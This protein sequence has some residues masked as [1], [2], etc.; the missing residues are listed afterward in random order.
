MSAASTR[1]RRTLLARTVLRWLAA[2]TALLPKAFRRR[3]GDD[4]LLAFEDWLDAEERGA[5][6]LFSWAVRA[7]WVLVRTAVAERLDPTAWT[8]GQQSPVEAMARGELPSPR[9]RYDYG[10]NRMKGSIMDRLM[11]DLR[12]AT[13]AL[14]RRPAYVL[15]AVLT[16]ALGVGANAAI[17]SLVD[18][19]ILRPLPYPDP[20]ELVVVERIEADRPNERN[21]MSLLDTADVADLSK[22]LDHLVGYFDTSV[23]LAAEGAP[24]VLQ[25]AAVAGSLL[26]VFELAPQM[27]R[28]LTREDSGPNAPLRAL[29]GHGLWQSRFGGRGD[30]VGQVAVFDD[31][32]YEIVGV[33][34]EG[35]S[36]PA[37]T[38]LWINSDSDPDGCGRGCHLFDAIGRLAPGALLGDA[39]AELARI[40]GGLAELHP[41]SN[42]NKTFVAAPLA[43]HL[44]GEARGGLLILLG[45]VA[46]V[47]LIAAANLAGLQL[48]HGASRRGEMGVRA[49]L[50]ASRWR[51]VRLV[52]AETTLLGLVGGLAGLGLAAAALRFVVAV[53]PA[54]VPRLGDAAVDARVFAF[55]LA[56][57]LLAALLFGLYPAWRLAASSAGANRARGPVSDSADVRLRG[58]LLVGEIALSM[59]LLVG[60]GLLLKTY[61]GLLTLDLG[62]DR[63]DVLCFFVAAPESRYDEPEKVVALTEQIHQELGSLP[64]IESV[65]GILGRPFSGNTLGTSF[66]LLDEPRPAEGDEPSTRIRIVMPGYFETLGIPL[67]V[68]RLPELTDRHGGQPVALVNQAWVRRH[69]ADRSPI[70]RQLE[71]G[72]SFGWDEPPRTIVGVVGDVLGESITGAPEV[73]V[74]APQAQM[75][76][77]WM[78]M[79]VRTRGGGAEPWTAIEAAVRRVDPLLPLHSRETLA[80]S[81]DRAQGPSRF[82]F[83][84]LAC[85]AALAVVLAA[86]GL[87]G[88]VSYVVARRSRELAVR[89]AL[90]A[91]RRG[92]VALVLAQGMR[93]VALGAAIGLLASVGA[94]RFLASLLHRVEAF[95]PATY[96]AVTGVLG[97]VAFAAL[98]APARRAGRVAPALVLKEE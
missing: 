38:V 56:L 55:G 96:A 97:L 23:T 60:A 68:G 35:F 65:G 62:F 89:L 5:A 82:Y 83:V 81:V 15:V 28:D 31:E 37:E 6:A 94:T 24:E 66:H 12:F 79:V 16:L 76:S 73:E 30:I 75:G 25:T 57:A 22:T 27:G 43:D 10:T 3:F 49:A 2:L 61:V 44:L 69:S 63:E 87:Y 88:I 26:E 51:I 93:P 21:A 98:L 20:E 64:E 33:A 19:V 8:G 80:A 50:G 36:F 9:K 91:D 67:V 74:Y 78:G 85:F 40:A 29:L 17:F 77:P 18:A 41:E 14:A 48:A 54:G 46:L 47:L 52:L 59:A 70:G 1:P 45:A 34:P 11:Q 86:V 42:R 90:G 4:L 13:R 39:E 84:L 92:I 71:L 32:S 72:V 58:A 7:S 95:D 53:A